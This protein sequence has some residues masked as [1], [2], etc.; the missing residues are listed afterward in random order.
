[1][2]E[3]TVSIIIPTTYI[4]DH[5]REIVSQM[6]KSITHMQIIGNYYYFQQVKMPRYCSKQIK[7]IGD[8]IR[9]ITIKQPRNICAIR[10]LDMDY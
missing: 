7:N 3:I 8:G 5:A 9:I 10:E 2:S 6:K 4:I 1:M